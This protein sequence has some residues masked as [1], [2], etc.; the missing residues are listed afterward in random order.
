MGRRAG[1]HADKA[2]RQRFEER[3]HLATPE[4]LPNDDLFGRVNAVNLEHVLGDIQTDR[5]NLHVD[6]SP[7]VIRLRRTTLWHSMPGAGAVHHIMS[8]P[9][10]KPGEGKHPYV[11][12]RDV[13]TG[14]PVLPRMG[15]RKK[16]QR[17]PNTEKVAPGSTSRALS[18][19]GYHEQS[20]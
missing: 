18:A 19:G 20:R 11:G 13:I 6:G 5:G 17:P 7:H 4:L 10:R 9:R 14:K 3:Q 16:R 1:F 15:T 12:P 8:R 2:R